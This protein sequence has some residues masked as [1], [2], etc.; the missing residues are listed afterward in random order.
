MACPI[1]PTAG[2]FGGIIGGYIGVNPPV[3]FGG[4]CLS[5]WTTANLVALTVIGLK[6]FGN[7]AICEGLG[8]SLKGLSLIFAK[9]MVLGI[10]YSIGVNYLLNR[11][12]YGQPAPKEEVLPP[13]CRKGAKL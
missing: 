12:V 9:T 1:C 2:F 4:K 13:C 7:I 8:C 3:T 11:F 10:I 5:A 6:V